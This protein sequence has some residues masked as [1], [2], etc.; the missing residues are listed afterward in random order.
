MVK[1]LYFIQP[2]NDK[3]EKSKKNA[4][5]MTCGLLHYHLTIHTHVY[6]PAVAS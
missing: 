1:S 4:D 5:Y 3:D 2:S 6:E